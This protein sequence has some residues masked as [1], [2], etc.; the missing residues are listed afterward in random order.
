MK[1]PKPSANMLLCIADQKVH[2]KRMAEEMAMAREHILI[3]ILIDVADAFNVP[4]ALIQ[5]GDQQQLT[6]LVRALYYYI[7]RAKTEYGLKYMAKVAGRKDH[8]SCLPQLRKVQT[9][10][11]QKDEEFLSIWDHYLSKS[12]LFTSKDF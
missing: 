2:R 10:F 11:T 12:K 9:F 7:V 4:L 6:V 5:K 1:L 8:T 3:N